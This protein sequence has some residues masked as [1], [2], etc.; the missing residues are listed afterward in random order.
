MN[1]A[2][3]MY[4][5]ITTRCAAEKCQIAC[6]VGKES[7]KME[8]WKSDLKTEQKSKSV[9]IAGVPAIGLQNSTPHEL[10]YFHA[11]LDSVPVH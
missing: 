4:A 1:P 8:F 6:R 7:Y 5:R 11:I 2:S 10:P 9:L 3:Q